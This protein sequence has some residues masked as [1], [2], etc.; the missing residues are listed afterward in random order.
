LDETL[1]G[2]LIHG[3][4]FQ[5]LNLLQERYRE[6]VACIYIDPP[7][8][9]DAGPITYKNGYRSSSWIS[10]MDSRLEL[11]RDLLNTDGIMCATIDDYQVNELAYLLDTTFGYP[12]RLGTSVIRNNPS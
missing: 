2:L 8:N 5:A 7:Y 10:M 1:D 11:S 9:T 12:S 3:D 4:N 6:Q